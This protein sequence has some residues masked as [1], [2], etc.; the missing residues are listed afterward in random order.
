MQCF[1]QQHVQ[2]NQNV[3][4]S[5]ISRRHLFIRAVK[6]QFFSIFHTPATLNVRFQAIGKVLSSANIHGNSD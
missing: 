4:K 3:T 5:P 2:L 6:E 1:S